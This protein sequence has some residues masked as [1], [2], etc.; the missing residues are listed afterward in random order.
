[1]YMQVVR[2]EPLTVENF[3][4]FGDV[5]SCEG[6]DFFHINDAH[7]ERYH[8]IVQTQKQGQSNIGISIF[9]NIKTTSLPLRIKMLEKHPQ[10]SQA[11]IP[12]SGQVFLIVVAPALNED[13]PDVLKIRAFLSNG[14]QGVN[15]RI[16]TWHHP[17]LTLES[18]SDFAVIDRIG[19]GHNCDVFEFDLAIQIGE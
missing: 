18:P 7:T 19:T 10:G 8:N 1:M 5:I 11:F 6:H 13:C 15:Y 17:L 2:I 3:A 12:M 9:R 14:K 16:N 4:P